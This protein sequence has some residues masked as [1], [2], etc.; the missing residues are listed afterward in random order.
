MQF[1]QLGP[2][3]GAQFLGQPPTY[4]V[5]VDQGV[6]RLPGGVQSADEHRRD[7]L[8]EGVLAGHLRQPAH[9]RAR[10]ATA[11]DGIGPCHNRL[12]VILAQGV[13]GA[14]RPVSRQSGERLTAPQV[15]RL[16]QNPGPVGVSAVRLP[17]P[18]QQVLPAADV[19]LVGWQV[20]HVAAGTAAQWLRG[21]HGTGLPQ[22]ASDAGNLD[23]QGSAGAVRCL[24]PDTVDERI[25][26]D[27]SPQVSRQCGQDEPLLRWPRVDRPAVDVQLDRPQQSHPDHGKDPRPHRAHRPTSTR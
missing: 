5:V 26:G 11:Q 20:E 13:A 21:G 17:G 25:H 12:K 6:G 27:R 7:R 16:T 8:D 2:G 9:H 3:I 23:V 19:D 14:G 15:H 4:R 24:V 18:V 1:L 22:R 10:A